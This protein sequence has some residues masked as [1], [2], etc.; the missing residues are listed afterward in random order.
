MVSTITSDLED[1][2]SF[3]TQS[4]EH[5]DGQYNAITREDEDNLDIVSTSAVSLDYSKLEH[6][7]PNNSYTP[8]VMCGSLCA[9]NY[10]WCLARSS[11]QCDDGVQVFTTNNPGLCRNPT[12]W[13]DVPCTLYWPD[14]EIV[15]RGLRCTGGLQHCIYPWY[16]SSNNYYEACFLV[17][18]IN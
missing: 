13:R 18:S 16:L 15:A 2:H 5:N 4:N 6:C 17:M 9:H 14:G 3:C 8:G 12:F 1:G 10:R 11:S 7:T